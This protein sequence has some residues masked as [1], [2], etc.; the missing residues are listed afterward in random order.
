MS[1]LKALVVFLSLHTHCTLSVR[2]TRMLLIDVINR[3]QYQAIFILQHPIVKLG[4]IFEEQL[5]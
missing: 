5:M 4:I 1:E 3:C 2:Y